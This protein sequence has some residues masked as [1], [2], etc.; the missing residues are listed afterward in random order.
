MEKPMR[1]YVASIA[2]ERGW[3][4]THEVGVALHV[5]GA[6]QAPVTVWQPLETH[7]KNVAEMAR[8]FA[9]SFGAGE[10]ICNSKEGLH[11]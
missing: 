4:G 7:L 2:S 1:I 3:P 9:N 8:K 5:E 11:L 10:S 6:T